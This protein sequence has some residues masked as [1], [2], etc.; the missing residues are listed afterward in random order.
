M[1]TYLVLHLLLSTALAGTFTALLLQ[2]KTSLITDSQ[3]Q[4][5]KTRAPTTT[6][7]PSHDFS[8]ATLSIILPTTTPIPA[9]ASAIPV[10]S[11]PPPLVLPPGGPKP[12]PGSPPPPLPTGTVPSP[13]DPNVPPP[14]SGFPGTGVPLLPVVPS[15]GT[16]LP[17]GTAVPLALAGSAERVVLSSN[18]ALA[19]VLVWLVWI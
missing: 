18:F 5:P 10:P 6:S 16:L 7:H 11:T 8:S 12:V 2:I 19:M 3:H 1:P 9:T 17:A 15:S 13:W 14:P 4:S